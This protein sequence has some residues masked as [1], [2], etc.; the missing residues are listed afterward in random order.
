MIKTIDT[1][2][3]II[4]RLI[5]LPFL[6]GF[7]LVRNLFNSFYLTIMFTIFGGE[8]AA[9]IKNEKKTIYDTYKLIEKQLNET[10]GK[11]TQETKN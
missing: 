1:I 2:A 10:N 5:A 4:M 8:L 3:M 6:F 7:V 9:Y 11:T